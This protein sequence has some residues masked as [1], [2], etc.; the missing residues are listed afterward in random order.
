MHWGDLFSC[1]IMSANSLLLIQDIKIYASMQEI[2][3]Y[4]TIYV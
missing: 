2:Q 4:S 3:K 1:F